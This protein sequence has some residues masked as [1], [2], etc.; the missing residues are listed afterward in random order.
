MT[1]RTSQDTVATFYMWDGHVYNLLSWSFFS[2]LCIGPTTNIEIGSFL[3]KLFK[4]VISEIETKQLF[5]QTNS[6]GFSPA[7]TIAT[8]TEPEC[9]RNGQVSPSDYV[10]SPEMTLLVQVDVS[11]RR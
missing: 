9:H 7:D 10:D 3:T 2:I 5:L 8:Q 4:Q 11:G 1:F 6:S